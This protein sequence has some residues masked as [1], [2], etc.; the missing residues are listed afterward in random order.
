MLSVYNYCARGPYGM[1]SAFHCHQLLLYGG[2]P[3]LVAC[4]MHRALSQGWARRLCFQ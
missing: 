1:L 3:A 4:I 2:S